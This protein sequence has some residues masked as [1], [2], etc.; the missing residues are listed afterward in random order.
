MESA[1]IA[2]A[3]HI[4]RNASELFNSKKKDFYCNEKVLS[5]NNLVKEDHIMT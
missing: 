4:R 2:N 1:F 5:Y 3:N